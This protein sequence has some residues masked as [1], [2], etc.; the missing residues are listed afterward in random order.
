MEGTPAGP[1]TARRRRP[2]KGDLKENAI[3]ECA[4]RLLAEK[5]LSDIAIDQL[6][7]AAGISRPAF[8]F[9]FESKDAVL[10]ALVERLAEAAYAASEHWHEDTGGAPEE[11]IREAIAATARL[12]QEHGPVLRAA[13]QTWETAPEA[14]RFWEEIVSRFVE[15]SAGRIRRERRAGNAPDVGPS[16]KSL[17]TA[18]VWMNERCFYT[19]SLGVEPTLGER[20]LVATLTA[21]WM[22]AV[23]GTERSAQNGRR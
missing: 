19:A 12:W 6:A 17:A 1:A 15:A 4:E 10:Q 2:R 8:Y 9:Y 5:P 3:L 23:Y 11:S 22:R 7:R 13:V 18:L 21:V 20:D 14:H 16:A